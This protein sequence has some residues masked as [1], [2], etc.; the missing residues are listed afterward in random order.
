[1]AAVYTEVMSSVCV[2]N[3]IYISYSGFHPNA[4]LKITAPDFAP[5]KLNRQSAIA[6]PAVSSKRLE[7]D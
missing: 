4:E 7:G 5:E 2:D 1:M 3:N 6:Q